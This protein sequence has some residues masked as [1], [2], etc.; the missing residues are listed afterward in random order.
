MYIYIR[1]TDVYIYMYMLLYGWMELL[2]QQTRL[3]G[4][5]L[6]SLPSQDESKISMK[7]TWNCCHEK[8]G[9][10]LKT[11]IVYKVHMTQNLGIEKSQAF[12]NHLD[13]W[14]FGLQDG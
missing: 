1:Y 5:R 14:N 8:M 3:V 11:Y 9:A 4:G 13:V 2:D 10:P 6:C 12:R 7:K